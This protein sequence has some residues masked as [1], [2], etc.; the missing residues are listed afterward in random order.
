MT[1]EDVDIASF[2][3]NGI[4]SLPRTKVRDIVDKVWEKVEEVLEEDGQLDTGPLI[5][6]R[7]TFK[8]PKKKDTFDAKILFFADLPTIHDQL[9]GGGGLIVQAT[10]DMRRRQIVMV[11]NAAVNF[12]STA[13]RV[14]RDKMRR[15]F[16]AAVY[17]I[18]SHE[19]TH[20]LEPVPTFMPE[21]QVP[22]FA[23]EAAVAIAKDYVASHV[24]GRQVPHGHTY[25]ILTKRFAAKGGGERQVRIYVKSV[26]P[27]GPM[28]DL[29]LDAAPALDEHGTEA[30]LMVLDA[31]V[32]R[33]APPGISDADV[34]E[35]LVSSLVEPIMGISYQLWAERPN[36]NVV[37]YNEIVEVRAFLQQFWLELRLPNVQR[38]LDK[39]VREGRSTAEITDEMIGQSKTLAQNLEFLTARNQ[40]P[41]FKELA[42]TIERARMRA[43]SAEVRAV[44]RKAAP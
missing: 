39:M 22:A 40:Q 34:K 21:Y 3:P 37:Y 27:Y 5:A 31:R 33:H 18:L 19:F 13:E 26:I 42:A 30:I 29:V 41:F 17:D 32:L 11:L 12:R 36:F 16:V 1:A 10:T 25:S 9:R 2:F 35:A 14:G 6:F 38:K 7:D 20:L 23:S 4:I 28:E 24:P 15:L 44:A 43:K 8:T